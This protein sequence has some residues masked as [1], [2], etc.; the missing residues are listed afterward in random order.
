LIFGSIKFD[1]GPI[2]TR[3]FP[4]VVPYKEGI[5]NG[6]GKESPQIFQG[7]VLCNRSISSGSNGNYQGDVYMQAP[8]FFPME[9]VH[10]GGADREV[11]SRP[12]HDSKDSEGLE[13]AYSTTR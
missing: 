3:I 13:N 11:Q 8:C 4:G 5:S 2:T 10:R 7:M 6:V 9:G 1:A 12:P